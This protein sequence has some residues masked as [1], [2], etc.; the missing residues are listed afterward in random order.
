MK[1]NPLENPAADASFALPELPS[2]L[3]YYDDFVDGYISLRNLRNSDT[4]EIQVAGAPMLLEFSE[5]RIDLHALLKYWCVVQLQTRAPATV[6]IRF[7]SLQEVSVDDLLKVLASSPENIRTLWSRL[8]AKEYNNFHLNSLKSILRLLCTLGVGG[9]STEFFEFLQQLPL[10]TSDKYTSVRTGDVFLSTDEE[11]ALVEHFDSLSQKVLIQPVAVPYTELRDTT[12]L[13][14]SFQFGL[15]PIQIGRL[16]MRDV[17]IW[18]NDGSDVPSVHLTFKMAKQRSASRSL[19]LTRKVKREWAPLFVELFRRAQTEG[20]TGTDRLFVVDSSRT[21]ASIIINK[22]GK[23]LP[24]SRSATELR[25]TAAQRLVDA[26]AN[27]E[28]L[29]E[30]MGHSN[31]DTG[32]VYFHTSANQAERVNQALG[33]SSVYQQIAKIAHDRFIN[34]EELAQL[35]GELQIAGV[36]HGIPI[37]GIG[38]CASGQPACPYNPVTSCYG[39]RKFMPLNDADV[40]KTVLAEFRSIV[41]FFVDVGR[42]EKNTPTYLQLKRTI[43][44]VQSVIA[45]IEEGQA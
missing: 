6:Y 37:S 39:C 14:C 44:S 10:P 21:T 11:A 38:G 29:A 23:L 1:L 7:K 34:F 32:L 17:R 35:K 12:V 45:E 25:H 43:S 28:E 41:T 42:G 18:S 19:P 33:V 36:P 31:L 9:W 13:I 30:F 22:T 26:G 8:R 20:L 4:W 24:E 2:T 40:H 27:H 15:R 16:Q 5:F 3:R